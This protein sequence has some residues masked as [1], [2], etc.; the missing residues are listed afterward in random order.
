MALESHCFRQSRC[1]LGWHLQFMPSALTVGQKHAHTR[2]RAHTHTHTQRQRWISRE[3]P[4][5]LCLTEWV[6]LMTDDDFPR[7]LSVF[8]WLVI[9]WFSVVAGCVFPRDLL[10]YPSHPELFVGIILITDL[11]FLLVIGL[12]RFFISLWFTFGRFCVS[13]N[14]SISSKL[15]NLLAYNCS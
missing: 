2:T 10:W 5:E 13:R 12:I 9:Q 8:H 4:F 3:G 14:L 6:L 11:I 15:S 7:S 1:S